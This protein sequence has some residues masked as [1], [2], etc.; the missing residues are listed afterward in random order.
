MDREVNYFPFKKNEFCRKKRDVIYK[1][2]IFSYTMPVNYFSF[3]KNLP[4]TGKVCR[5]IKIV[6]G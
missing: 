1:L 4:S 6:V 5:D 2:I 3:Q